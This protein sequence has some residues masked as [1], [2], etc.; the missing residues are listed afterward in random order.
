MNKILPNAFRA[1]LANAPLRG[2]WLALGD[3]TAAE[4]MAT[5]GYDWLL[6]DGEHTPNT[7]RTILDQLRAVEPYPAA[8]V[9]RP[10]S[11][12]PELIKQLL[13]IGARTLMVPMIETAEQASALVA[14]TRYAPTGFR[15]VA[16][17]SIRADR[18]GMVADYG[19]TAADS[20]CLIAQIESQIGVDNAEAIVNTDGIDAIFVGPNDLST[21]MGHLGDQDSVDVQT[22]INHVLSVAHDAGKPVGIIALDATSIRHYRDAGFDFIA[23]GVDGLLLRNAAIANAGGSDA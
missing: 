11:K 23:T 21:N 4:I 9:V 18:W 1:K 20:L 8:P 7:I 14:A 13:D 16:I 12:A 22:A 17:G 2:G 6:I 5:A 10:V 15:G 3:A 19:A